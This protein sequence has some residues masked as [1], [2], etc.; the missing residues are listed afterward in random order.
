M[1]S[2]AYIS[3]NWSKIIQSEIKVGWV[4]SYVDP[5]GQTREYSIFMQNGQ[6]LALTS[7]K[8]DDVYVYAIYLEDRELCF[9]SIPVANKIHTPSEE[10]V[11]NLFNLCSSKVIWQEMNRFAK[12]PIIGQNNKSYS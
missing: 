2:D 6:F 4:S 3:S 11:L 10:R 9:M 7:E 5:S 8:I 1:D 12:G